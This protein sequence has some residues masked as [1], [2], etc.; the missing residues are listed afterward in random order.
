M[1]TWEL[2]IRNMNIEISEVYGKMFTV[3]ESLLVIVFVRFA[4]ILRM[5]R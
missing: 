3:L 5:W 1:K 2:Y 4:V